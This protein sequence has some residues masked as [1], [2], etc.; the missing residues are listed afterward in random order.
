[1]DGHRYKNA[2]RVVGD[3]TMVVDLTRGKTM[4]VDDTDDV[5]ILLARHRFYCHNRYAE[6][7]CPRGG[8]RQATVFFHNLLLRRTS[9]RRFVA[10][11]I[12]GDALDNREA[13]LRTVT[14][15]DDAINSKRRERTASG[16][17][18]LWWDAARHQWRVRWYL[19]CRP[20]VHERIFSIRR[21][22]S[23]ERARGVA[24]EFLA[25]TEAS[26]RLYSSSLARGRVVDP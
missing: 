5:R 10:D 8:G 14:R 19:P 4:I 12:N 1:M 7:K 25:R 26:I 18:N 23:K 11:H 20:G 22:G 21:H 15:Q 24:A 6:T 2:I 13:N 17:T 9:D 3:G 16:V